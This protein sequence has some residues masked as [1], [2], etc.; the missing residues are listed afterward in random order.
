MTYNELIN[1]EHTLSVEYVSNILA[2]VIC[3]DGWELTTFRATADPDVKTFGAAGVA[4]VNVGQDTDFVFIPTAEADFYRLKRENLLKYEAEMREAELNAS[5]GKDY[6]LTDAD[7]S[8]NNPIA[9]TDGDSVELGKWYVD[10][11]Y[12]LVECL[13]DG[14]PTAD[15]MADFFDL[16]PI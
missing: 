15:T 16:P 6:D 2:K 3:A 5:I 1:N 4:F 11:T 13:A 8:M 12:G 10:E 7:G 14:T 9:Y